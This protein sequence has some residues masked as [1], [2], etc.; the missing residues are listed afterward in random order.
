MKWATVFVL[1]LL[2][3]GCAAEKPQETTE[4]TTCATTEPEDPGIYARDHNIETQTNGAVR[5]YPLGEGMEAVWLH[6]AGDRLLLASGDGRLTVLAGDR[7]VQ[8]ATTNIVS[9]LSCWA[10]ISGGFAYYLE[11][12]SRVVFLDAKLQEFNTVKLPLQIEGLPLIAP[13]TGTVYYC[14]GDEIRAVNPVTGISHLIKKHTYQ[15]LQLQDICFDGTVLLCKA[16]DAQGLTETVF[17]SAQTGETLD[18]ETSLRFFDSC[19]DAYFATHM[20][21]IVL[22]HIYGNR[23]SSAQCVDIPEYA[24]TLVTVLPLNGAVT[25]KQSADAVELSFYNLQTGKRSAFVTLPGLTD[26][27]AVSADEKYVWFVAVQNGTQAVFRWDTGASSVEEDATCLY[28]LYTADTPDEAGLSQC[29]NR[30]NAIN[31]KYGVDISIWKNAVKKPGDYTLIPE[32]QVAA[33]DHCLNELEAVFAL[34]PDGFLKK[35]GESSGS[36]KIHICIVRNVSSG[37]PVQYWLNGDAYIVLTPEGDIQK[38]FVQKLGCVVDTHILGNSVHL[39]AWNDLNPNG[40]VYDYDYAANA[41]RTDTKYLE[42]E[43]RAFVDRIS[44]SFPTEDRAR[45]F[46]AALSEDGKDTFASETM[47]KKLRQLCIGIRYAYGWRRSTETFLWEQYL[48]ESLAYKMK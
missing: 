30:V 48:N 1:I 43:K 45:I 24:G 5:V 47:Q 4:T 11:D 12:E 7:C 41:D 9:D 36:G 20:D 44:M 13:K 34:F 37:E 25:C 28:P 40:F 42:G 46:A 38:A 33:I 6:P 26:M 39:D 35:T 2:L 23:A 22:R 19:G 8:E 21:G 17:L 32:Y 31:K 14:S 15:T 3:A 29:Q 27:K 10:P 18:T 16:T